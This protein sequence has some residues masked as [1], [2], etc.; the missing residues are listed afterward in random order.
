MGLLIFSISSW[1]SFWKFIFLRFSLF[2]LRCPFYWH[3]VADSSL[4]WSFVFLCCRL[5][6][7]LISNFVDLILLPLF[8]MTLSSGLSILFILSKNQV[9][10]LLIFLMI[11]SVSFALIY[12][13]IS[14]FSFL[15][16]TLGLF[17]SSFSS[18]FRCSVRLF[19]WLLSCFLR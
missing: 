3:I 10:A 16:L 6:S 7:I 15:L 11:S 17:S 4:L 14:K 1:F 18:C 19:I 5:W 13:R 2:L 12:A 9:L 8:L